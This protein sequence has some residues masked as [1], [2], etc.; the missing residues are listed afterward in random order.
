MKI[1]RV[2]TINKDFSNFNIYLLR[3]VPSGG[4]RF[5]VGGLKLMKRNFQV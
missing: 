3:S 2:R 1:K 4:A 5:G